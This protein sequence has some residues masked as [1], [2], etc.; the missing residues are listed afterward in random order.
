MQ[1]ILSQAPGSIIDSFPFPEE[2]RWKMTK[3]TELFRCEVFSK[4]NY[5]ITRTYHVKLWKQILREDKVI[6]TLLFEF[7][8]GQAEENITDETIPGPDQGCYE[9]VYCLLFFNFVDHFFL[10]ALCT[11]PNLPYGCLVQ[12]W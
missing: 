3:K 1:E 2:E 5:K 10:W 6:F 8:L 4:N 12:P 11:L 7:K 9:G